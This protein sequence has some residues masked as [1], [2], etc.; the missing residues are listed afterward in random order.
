MKSSKILAALLSLTL[1]FS[2]SGCT[3]KDP[4]N[5]TGDVKNG[6]ENVADGSYEGSGS[7]HGG[8]LKLA[9]TVKDHKITE[10]SVIEHQETAGISDK[11]LADLPGLI[12][13]HQSLAIDTNF[14]CYRNI[15]SNLISS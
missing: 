5:E 15:N 9:V 7:G 12:V 14:R 10:V 11:P 3:T 1:F 6:L 13:D 4:G 2:M 8:D